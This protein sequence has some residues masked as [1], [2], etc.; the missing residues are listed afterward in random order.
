VKS[1]EDK[2]SSLEVVL[3]YFRSFVRESALCVEFTSI[4]PSVTCCQRLNR[5]AD[6]LEN[7]YRSYLFVVLLKSIK[8]SDF[9]TVERNTPI[10]SAYTY[11]PIPRGIFGPTKENQIGRVKTNEELDKLIKHKNIINYI[12]AQRLSWFGHV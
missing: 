8:I 7:W 9:A 4:G 3:C 12:K 11:F 10:W 2:G 1:A 6:F 5:L